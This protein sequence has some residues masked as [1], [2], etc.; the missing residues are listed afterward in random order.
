MCIKI[1]ITVCIFKD[2]SILNLIYVTENS[3]HYMSWKFNTEISNWVYRGTFRPGTC[4]IQHR[5][6]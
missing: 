5:S 1:Q 4:E 6:I 2:E 3:F